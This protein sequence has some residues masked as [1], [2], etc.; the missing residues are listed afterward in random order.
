MTD[1]RGG[2]MSEAEQAPPEVDTTKPSAARMYDYYLGGTNNYEVDRIAAEQ[3]MRMAPDVR[4]A[5]WSNRGFHQRAAQWLAAD[6]RITQFIDVGSG[7][8][9]QNN[10]HDA[11]HA[12][13]PEA[14]VVYVD[15]DPSVAE[16]VRA[17]L[18]GTGNTG[19]VIGDLRDKNSIVGAPEL[20]E[21][22]DM[23]K[24]VA[25]LMTA[26]LH[27]VSDEVD[28]Y[29]LIRTYLEASAPGSYLVLSHATEDKGRVEV[30]DRT[31]E[32]YQRANEQLYLRSRS[33]VERFFEGLELVPPYKGAPPMVTYA[34]LWGAEDPE[35]ADDDAN[36]WFYCGVARKP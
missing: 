25:W 16:E 24:P 3:V 27:F 9:T 20:L 26:L 31:R 28:P 22:I 35:S 13:N 4:D 6:G 8:P 18:A 29:G 7:L 33:E 5:V 10:T 34:G 15:N 19:F 30:G 36:R 14:R 17:L 11:V 23:D 1:G 32:I 21:L 12:V 2:D